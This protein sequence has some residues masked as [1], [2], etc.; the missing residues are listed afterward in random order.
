[1]LAIVAASARKQ[2]EFLLRLADSELVVLLTLN[3]NVLAIIRACS[4]S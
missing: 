4:Q 2:S 3:D 1:V